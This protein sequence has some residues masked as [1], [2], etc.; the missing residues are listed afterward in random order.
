MRK[1]IF[2][3]L[4]TVML[5]FTMLVSTMVQAKTPK[6]FASLKSYIQVYGP[7]N[8]NYRYLNN[9]Y[10][11]KISYQK[12][13]KR[14]VFQC[15]YTNGNSTSSIAM[16]VPAI[17]KNSKYKVA[18]AQTIRASG[19]TAKMS[20][21]AKLK[22]KT[23]NDNAT[24]LR[25]SRLNK[26]SVSKKIKN[27]AYQSA[28]NALLKFAFKLWENGLETKMTLCFRNLGFN[29]ITVIDASKV[30]STKEW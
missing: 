25:F 12:K 17:K 10:T 7:I 23:Y 28:A 18:F 19:K 16:Y 8:V 27:N 21:T 15:S 3:I 1:R 4:L 14:F 22:R 5:F 30:Y 2:A 29:K 11:S 9:V 24:N 20:G 26:T 6:A 13:N